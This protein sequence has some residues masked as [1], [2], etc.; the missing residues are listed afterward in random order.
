M[1]YPVTSSAFLMS[2]QHAM[3]ILL[4]VDFGEPKLLHL[5]DLLPLQ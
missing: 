5:G 2:L 3:H 1:L 4:E